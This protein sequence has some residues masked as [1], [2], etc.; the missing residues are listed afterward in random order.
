MNITAVVLSFVSAFASGD[1]K[2]VLNAIQL[3]WV[4][5]IMDIFAAL[6]QAIDPPT[7][8]QLL[9]LPD[10]KRTARS[11]VTLTMW[12]M[13]VG[14][15]IYQLAVGLTLHF[16]ELGSFLG[17]DGETEQRTLVLTCLCLCRSSSWLIVGGLVI[18]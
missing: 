9:C 10:P 2:S 5:F 13:I 18:G 4:N 16:A 7:G 17:S 6:A 11:L 3:L 8:S 1:E 15:A 12:K 14:Q